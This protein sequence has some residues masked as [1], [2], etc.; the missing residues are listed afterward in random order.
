VSDT[1]EKADMRTLSDSVGASLSLGLHAAKR[2]MVA[3]TMMRYLKNLF[4]C[5]C[6]LM[7]ETY[8]TTKIT[9]FLAMATAQGYIYNNLEINIGVF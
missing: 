1:N 2:L 5:R 3:S 9:T 7:Y 4:I 8:Q 6:C